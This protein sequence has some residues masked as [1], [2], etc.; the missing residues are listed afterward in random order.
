M[1]PRHATKSVQSP[2]NKPAGRLRQASLDAA[3]LGL[4]WKRRL[5]DLALFQREFGSCHVSTLSKTHASLGNWVRTQR[6][7]RKRGELNREQI[8]ALDELGFCWDLQREQN[9]A[10]WESMYKAL[11]AFQQAHGH[12]RVSQVQSRGDRSPLARWVGGQRVARRRGK[13]SASRVRRLNALGFCWGARH[14]K[15]RVG[16][17]SMYEALAAFQ[18]ARGHCR[19]PASR[20]DKDR[21]RLARWVFAQ[22]NA[23]RRDELTR[24]RIRRLDKLGFAWDPWEEKWEKM[25]AALVKYKKTHG[26]CQVPAGWPP[27]PELAAWT[28]S[29]RS[30]ASQGTLSSRRRKRL[31]QLGFRFRR[32]D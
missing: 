14:T 19:V 30:G 2:V 8:A 15:E 21:A 22:R 16:W 26:D 29:Q 12:C 20:R 6:V 11:A 4:G 3:A 9:R 1:P 28:R 7:R 13:L 32:G 25:F 5:L 31:A 27:N 10:Q 18:R 24:E 17:E 23:R